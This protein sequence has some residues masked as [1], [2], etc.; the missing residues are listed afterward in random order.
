MPLYVMTSTLNARPE[1]HSP[2]ALAGLGRQVGN[3]LHQLCPDVTWLGNYATLGPHDYVDILSAP[4]HHTA[5]K[6][7]LAVRIFGQASTAMWPATRSPIAWRWSPAA[8][9]TAGREASS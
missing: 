7:Q 6:V 1:T 4:D 8:V 3:T 2:D 5:M 9:D